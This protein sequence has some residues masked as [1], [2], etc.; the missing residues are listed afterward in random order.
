MSEA[1]IAAIVYPLALLFA[2]VGLLW[3]WVDMHLRERRRRRI[4]AFIADY[5]REH[6][7]ACPVCSFDRWC[8]AQGEGLFEHDG[9]QCPEQQPPKRGAYR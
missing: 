5:E 6:P 7:G 1:D 3:P 4:A 8:R 9:H 2:V